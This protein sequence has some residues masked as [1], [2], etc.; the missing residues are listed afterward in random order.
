MDTPKRLYYESLLLVIINIPVVSH[1]WASKLTRLPRGRQ[2]FEKFSLSEFLLFCFVSVVALVT[3]HQCNIIV[4]VPFYVGNFPPY[5]NFILILAECPGSLL[6][7]N[8][9][10][11]HL[12]QFQFPKCRLYFNITVYNQN[13]NYPWTVFD[14]YI[15]TA[16]S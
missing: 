2:P 11:H 1:G 6:L 9:D 4:S 12:V 14:T 13:Q 8:R 15:Y 3:W 5:V 10:K 7:M 16:M